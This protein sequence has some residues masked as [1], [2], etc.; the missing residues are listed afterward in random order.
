[1]CGH[2]ANFEWSQV[3]HRLVR[4]A[5][6][7]SEL[8]VCPHTGGCKRFAGSLIKDRLPGQRQG[9]QAWVALSPGGLTTQQYDVG[10]GSR[11]Q[12]P[13]QASNDN[14]LTCST[15]LPFSTRRFW[16][17]SVYHCLQG[18]MATKTGWATR[19]TPQHRGLGRLLSNE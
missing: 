14:G 8:A 19:L 6:A 11:V 12:S 13:W 15:S 2:T 4:L 3:S 5:R 7:H 9:E 18:S 10:A 1:M 16:G 17:T